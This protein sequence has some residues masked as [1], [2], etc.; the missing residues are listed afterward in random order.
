MSDPFALGYGQVALAALLILI[1]GALSLRLQLGLERQMLVAA[2]R[3]VVQLL[4]IGFVLTS[5]F[6]LERAWA[7]VGLMLI[8]V[9]IA[10]RAAIQRT[11]LR[12]PGVGWN[13]FLAI[14]TAATVSVGLGLT[15]VL[16]IDP[17]WTPR[18][19]IPVLGMV[20][21]NA[22][23]GVSLGV[24]RL[25]ARLDADR[26]TIDAL[27]ALGATRWE[28]SRAIVQDAT[29]TGMTPILNAMTIA[30]VVSLPGMMTGQIL[31]GASPIEAVKYQIVIFFLIAATTALGTVLAVLLGVRR[32]FTPAHQF[33]ADQLRAAG[34]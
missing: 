3:M 19:A 25:A 6:D 20:L 34:G 28:A 14:A 13:S 7:V 33:R 8:M 9:I 22:L 10:S 2:A 31:A 18:F 24:D 32:L 23:N 15:V 29:R 16:Q 12:Y 30:G 11:S 26:D 27:L 4:L 17:W 5:I 21:G 1:N